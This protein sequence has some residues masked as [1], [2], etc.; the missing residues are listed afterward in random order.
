MEDIS[1]PYNQNMPFSLLPHFSGA[2]R[3]PR[4]FG[5]EAHRRA[6]L[7]GP[8]SPCAGRVSRRTVYSDGDGV[9]P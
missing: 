6:L 9:G 2:R 8:P 5:L 7:G 1:M 3:G 4:T